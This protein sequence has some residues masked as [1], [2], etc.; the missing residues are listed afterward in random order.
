MATPS[1][2]L[3]DYRL[4]LFDVD[5][6]LILKSTKQI[7]Q[8]VR[9]VL[10]K[11]AKADL[12][13]GVCTGKNA[14][15]LKKNIFPMFPAD[16]LHIICG[17]S[18]IVDSDCKILWQKP[19][20]LDITQQLIKLLKDM[21]ADF[22]IADVDCY[23][24]TDFFI[25]YVKQNYSIATV[26]KVEK[27][28]QPAPDIVVT[29]YDEAIE[30]ALLDSQLPVTFKKQSH[31]TGA[32]CDI[33]AAGVTKATALEALLQL[34]QINESQV[35]GFGDDSNDEEFLQL[36]GFAVAMGNGSPEVKAIAQKVIG[37]VEAGGL[38]QY[39]NQVLLT[40]QL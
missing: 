35:V 19:I 4:F 34:T 3:S 36:C 32:S 14:M 9:E 37:G 27:F 16:S 23:Y 38:P 15:F 8:G 25:N 1:T 30:K 40:R 10:H 28:N 18:Y 39:L 2:L 6:T 21:K 17:G 7:P 20:P 29:K 31:S 5:N 11:L 13:L 22:G 26:E 24:G 33:T 12:K